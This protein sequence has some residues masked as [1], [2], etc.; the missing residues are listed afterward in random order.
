MD[1][2]FYSYRFRLL[3]SIVSKELK[4]IKGKE[5]IEILST[6]NTSG[7][8]YDRDLFNSR[9]SSHSGDIYFDVKKNER[10]TI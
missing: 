6:M 10:K 9:L 2:S 1:C 4:Q 8:K 5:N 3:G 7:K